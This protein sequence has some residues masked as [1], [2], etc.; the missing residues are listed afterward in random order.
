[1]RA[2]NALAHEA[3]ALASSVNA[4]G[5]N[6]VANVSKYA[7]DDLFDKRELQMLSAEVTVRSLNAAANAISASTAVNL[8]G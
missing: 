5:S 3:Q 1:M 2:N 4:R 8:E 7:A 6:V